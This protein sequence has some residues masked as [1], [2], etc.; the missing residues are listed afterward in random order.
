MIVILIRIG[1]VLISVRRNGSYKY[2]PQI[3]ELELRHVGVHNNLIRGILNY[4][5]VDG[6]VEE[7]SFPIRW[8]ITEKGVK[9]IEG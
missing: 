9:F 2:L 8:Q 7:V 3:E 6:H 5:Q 1:R 4:L